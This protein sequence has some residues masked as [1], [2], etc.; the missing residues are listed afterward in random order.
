M[1]CLKRFVAAG[2][3]LGLA[4]CRPLDPPVLVDASVVV[5]YEELPDSRTIPDSWGRLVGVTPGP[6]PRVTQLWFENEDG[7]IRVAMF[8]DQLRQL[9]RRAAVVERQ[10]VE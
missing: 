2:F 7:V 10:E 6:W 9:A 8:N 5:A 3:V 1:P 4:A